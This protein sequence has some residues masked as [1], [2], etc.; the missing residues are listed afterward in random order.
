MKNN[1]QADASI[2]T[3]NNLLRIISKHA[4]LDKPEQ[5]EQFIANLKGSNTYKHNLCKTYLKYCRFYNIQWQPT[6]YDPDTKAIKIPT[7]EKLEMLIA[8][9][10]TILSIKLQ[11]SMETGMRPVEI[12][13]LK[14]KDIAL[15]QRQ[16][17]PSVHKHGASRTL[18]ISAQ[19]RD[20]IQEH[21]IKNKPNLND[22]IFKGNQTNYGN[23]YREM[24]NR[25]A[26]RLHDPTL[27]TVRLYDF[28]HY[29]ATTLYDK[30]KDILLV[31]QQMG[32]K[33]IETT[34][35]YTQLLNYN[36]EEY[37]CRTATT[38]K[39]ATDLLE[40]GFTYIQDIDGIKLYRKR[41]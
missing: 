35:I 30:T 9:A 19:L 10:G 8:S 27:K 12:M 37:T 33:R 40:H 39:E 25:L 7:K 26:E 6:K 31:K 41:K 4:S 11:I 28:R 1:G 20:S 14:V 24:R 36:E 21:I 22:N 34:M 38:I 17:Y 13:N 32:H 15:D 3:A 18:K 16:L 23:N 29:F 5:V 2:K